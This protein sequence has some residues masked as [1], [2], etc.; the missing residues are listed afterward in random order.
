VLRA[1]GGAA[2]ELELLD[3]LD[4]YPAEEVLR[5][6]APG[7]GSEDPGFL[8]L[9]EIFANAGERSD[10]GR[11]FD[12]M[13]QRALLA[14]AHGRSVEGV[15]S[16]SAFTSRVARALKLLTHASSSG[17]RVAAFTSAGTIGALAGQVLATSPRR[18]LELGWTLN[19]ASVT[20]LVFSAGRVGLVRLNTIG[21]LPDPRTWTRR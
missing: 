13:L 21:H 14:W 1:R 6:L 4:E 19:N 7:L 9:A 20:E 8:E 11:A 15:E 17:L 2:T 16:H 12:K 5:G 3:E 10:R 18:T